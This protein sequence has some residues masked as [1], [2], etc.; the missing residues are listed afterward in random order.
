MPPV[1]RRICRDD[2]VY[3][4]NGRDRGKTGRVLEVFKDTRLPQVIVEG[5]NMVSPNLSPPARP[6]A[7][8]PWPRQP[9]TCAHTH[10]YIVSH[11][12][13]VGSKEFLFVG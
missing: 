8:L 6:R 1:Y 4:L 9:C 2:V 12:F 5:C 7:R 10:M 11:V 3:I 13:S